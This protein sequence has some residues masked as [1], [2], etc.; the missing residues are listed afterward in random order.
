[1]RQWDR[2]ER[3]DLG[4]QLWL[5]STPGYQAAEKTVAGAPAGCP[6]VSR[7]F[8]VLIRYVEDKTGAEIFETE[9]AG[10][11]FSCRKEG[12]NL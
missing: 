3:A 7:E 9:I 11:K 5:P 1:M 6:S 10:E 12:W 8:P 2:A 4:F